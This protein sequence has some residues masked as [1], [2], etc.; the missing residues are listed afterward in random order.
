MKL[1]LIDAAVALWALFACAAFMLPLIGFGGAWAE[2]VT[3][4]RY[5]YTGVVAA[6]LV[7]LALRLIPRIGGQ[8]GHE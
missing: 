1:S 6:G 3:V 5:V 2:L 4:A 7:G 8:D